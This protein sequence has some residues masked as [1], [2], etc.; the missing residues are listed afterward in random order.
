[1]AQNDSS[2]TNLVMESVGHKRV[3]HA[4]SGI[5]RFREADNA[6]LARAVVLSNPRP[7]AT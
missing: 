6:P 2:S 4:P 5:D 7:G 3:D 1:M